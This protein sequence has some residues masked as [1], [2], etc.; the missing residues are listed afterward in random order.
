MMQG[1]TIWLVCWHLVY[2]FLVFN[3]SS[4]TRNAKCW[5]RSLN[6]ILLDT[7]LR[8]GRA[9][10]HASVAQASNKRGALDWRT[11]IW[12][13]GLYFGLEDFNCYWTAAK[14]WQW[15][16]D[17]DYHLKD[18]RSHINVSLSGDF[19][20]YWGAKRNGNNSNWEIWKLKTRY[21]QER[22]KGEALRGEKS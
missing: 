21:W 18:W 22:R 12:T 1:M 7:S 8:S 11:L 3:I 2:V 6:G 15:E 13:G 20:F 10:L 16:R 14:Q 9:T 19:I 5:W 4:C 17:E